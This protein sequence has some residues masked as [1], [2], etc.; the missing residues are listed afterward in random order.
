MTRFEHVFWTQL[1]EFKDFQQLKRAAPASPWHRKVSKG[2]DAK[3]QNMVADRYKGRYTGEDEFTYSGE[4]NSKIESIRDGSSKMRIL[5][6]IDL[7]YILNNYSTNELPKDKPKRIFAGVVVYFD[8]MKDS[9][10]IKSDE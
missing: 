5:S 2:A 7:Q 4:L 8:P 6:D 3:H 1:N 9:Y 10:C